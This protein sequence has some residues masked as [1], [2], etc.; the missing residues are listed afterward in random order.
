[1]ELTHI[2]CTF[3]FSFILAPSCILNCHFKLSK[4]SH[5]EGNTHITQKF[6]KED[7]VKV[8][9]HGK[10]LTHKYSNDFKL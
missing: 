5:G 9:N 4:L 10:D 8:L 3:C 2:Y 1:M 6:I 7:R